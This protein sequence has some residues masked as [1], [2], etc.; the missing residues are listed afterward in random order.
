[1]TDAWLGGCLCR[2]GCPDFLDWRVLGRMIKW[3]LG[4][5]EK[6][7][8][9]IGVRLDT[10][11]RINDDIPPTGLYFGLG[12]LQRRLVSVIYSGPSLTLG[13]SVRRCSLTGVT[14]PRELPR[15]MKRKDFHRSCFHRQPPH[16]HLTSNFRVNSNCHLQPNV[17][18]NDRGS[19]LLSPRTVTRPP[20]DTPARRS[21]VYARAQSCCSN[22]F[23]S[24][25]FA[26]PPP[27]ALAT[28]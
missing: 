21:I 27:S 15:R 9:H 5:G 6:I 17:D 8:E 13:L 3:D 28:D 20:N 16:F 11:Y 10:D 12:C 2:L 4:M 19:S 22:S 26:H 25:L 14:E 23:V 18:L 1:M 24:R 7:L